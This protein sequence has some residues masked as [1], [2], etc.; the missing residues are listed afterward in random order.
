MDINYELNRELDDASPVQARITKFEP[1]W[2]NILVE[3]PH[4]LRDICL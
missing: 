1:K 2:Q 3:V 4:V